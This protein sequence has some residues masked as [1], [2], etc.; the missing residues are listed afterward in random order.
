MMISSFHRAISVGFKEE[1]DF[2]LDLSTDCHVSWT[3]AVDDVLYFMWF[4]SQWQWFIVMPHAKCRIN[5]DNNIPTFV[6]S[7]TFYLICINMLNMTKTKITRHFWKPHSCCKIYLTNAYQFQT[8]FSDCAEWWHQ[9]PNVCAW[10]FAFI[11][12]ARFISNGCDI[13]SIRQQVNLFQ[14]D[15]V[16]SIRIF[17]K[18]ELNNLRASQA[19]DKKKKKP[20]NF[21]NI[22]RCLRYN[23]MGTHFIFSHFLHSSSWINVQLTNF[24]FINTD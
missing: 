5:I 1:I 19:K 13:N 20:W 8:R 17:K 21:S 10:T 4:N 11:R 15:Y 9:I 3:F 6:V 18:K 14:V 2:F 12:T 23:A 7:L 16:M 22:H 24:R